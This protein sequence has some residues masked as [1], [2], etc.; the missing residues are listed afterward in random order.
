MKDVVVIGAGFSGLASAILLALSGR[1]VTVVEQAERTAPLLRNYNCRGFEINNGFH[2]LGGY[3]PG[4]ALSRMFD[5]LGLSGRLAPIPL[6]PD[7]F[8]SF[9]GLSPRP[10]RV[11]IGPD[12]VQAVLNDAFPG[13]ETVLKA[14]FEELQK[15]F[16]E[17]DF[18]NLEEFFFRADPKLLTWTLNDHLEAGGATHELIMFLNAYSEMLLGVTAREVPFLT[19]LLGVGSYFLAAHTFVGG[20]GAL[21]DALEARA[22]EAGVH[23]RT[24]C[25]A[26]A[27]EAGDHRRFAAV[28]VRTGEGGEERLEAESCVSTIHP[29]RLMALLPDGLSSGLFARRVAGY[30]D[31]KAIHMFHLAVKAGAAREYSSN[32]HHFDLTGIMG[33]RHLI[34]LLPDMTRA[35]DP[36]AAEVRMSCLITAWDNDKT[37]TCPGS[38]GPDCREKPRPDGDAADSFAGGTDDRCRDR[39]RAR[40]EAAHPEL[41]GAYRILGVTE[42]CDLDRMTSTWN[43]SIYGLKCAS[44]RLGMTPMGPLKGL[45]LAGQSII[46]PGIFGALVSACLVEQRIRRRSRE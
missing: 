4:G 19:H 27:I 8:D 20:G 22:L 33:P 42:P 3:S 30:R 13:N 17:F 2:Y 12:R 18:L 43:G 35:A 16:L 21:A 7:G 26:V 25:R 44:D 14:Y 32:W 28:R 9:M 37:G 38:S 24:G 40:L 11:P 39:F 10:L 1:G 36:D 31:T 46:A 45:H 29:K 5:H 34:T 6:N 23:I 41:R 15:A